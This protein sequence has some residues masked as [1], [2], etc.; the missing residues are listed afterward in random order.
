MKQ[1]MSL[2]R[3]LAKVRVPPIKSQGIKTKLVRFIFKNI[4]WGGN[5]KYIEPFLGSGV[6]LFNL[7][8]ENAIAG[9]INPHTISFYKKLQT[10]E[11]NARKVK[12]Y[13]KKEGELLLTKGA[14]YYYDVRD[15]FNSNHDPL[16]LLFLNRSCFNGVMR[17]NNKGGFNVPFCKKPERFRKAYI[18]L[19][20]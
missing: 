10:G 3:N 4:R 17:F 9:E 20:G 5:G 16:D 18:M 13:L 7:A 15:R 2:P 8:P 14:D 1:K 19:N 12:S 6:V 11:L